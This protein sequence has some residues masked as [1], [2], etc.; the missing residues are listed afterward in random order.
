[1][2]RRWRRVNSCRRDQQRTVE[3]FRCPLNLFDRRHWCRFRDRLHVHDRPSF[4]GR[5]HQGYGNGGGHRIRARAR[6]GRPCAG[7]S[8][9][10]EERVID[11]CDEAVSVHG[12]FHGYHD[13]RAHHEVYRVR[14]RIATRQRGVCEPTRSWSAGKCLNGATHTS[15]FSRSS[16]PIRLLCIS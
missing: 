7:S 3:S 9:G 14:N 2:S 6:G 15:I 16:R 12:G 5:G 13:H 10:D 8:H 4:L 1:V 11:H